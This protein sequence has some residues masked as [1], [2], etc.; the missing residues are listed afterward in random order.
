MV[1]PLRDVRPFQCRILHLAPPATPALDLPAR[2]LVQFAGLRAQP[3]RA[4][5]PRRLQQMGV[6]V[7]LAAPATWCGVAPLHR[8]PL[9]P[10]PS[11]C[12]PHPNPPP[13]PRP[14]QERPGG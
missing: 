14:T 12:T 2:L 1:H 11:P 9:P 10:A 13:H 8:T 6:V 5:P 7:A 3:F 4:D